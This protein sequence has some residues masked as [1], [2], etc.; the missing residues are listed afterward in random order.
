MQGTENE[1]LGTRLG[2]WLGTLFF[3]GCLMRLVVDDDDELGCG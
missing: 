2:Y 3:G 1:W